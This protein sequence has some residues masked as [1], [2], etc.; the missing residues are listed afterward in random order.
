MARL[1]PLASLLL[2]SCQQEMAAQP[3]PR[4]DEPGAN[5]PLV[6]GTVA[7]GHLRTDAHLFTGT[8]SGKGGDLGRNWAAGAALLGLAGPK[9]GLAADTDALLLSCIDYR[10][11]DDVSAYMDGAGMKGKYDQVALAGAALAAVSPKFPYWNKTFWQHLQVAIDLHRIHQVMVI[12]HRDCGAFHVAYGTD[13][14]K[15]PAAETAIHTTVMRELRQQIAQ[16][17][18]ALDVSLALMALDGTVE[19]IAA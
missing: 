5:R 3:A 2:T 10:L 19:K 4:P 12:D 15:D 9:R 16:R 17:Q 6:R 11:V 14:G 13:F 1:L 8:R 7:R 18:P